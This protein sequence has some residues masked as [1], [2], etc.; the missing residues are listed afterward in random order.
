MIRTA[1][2]MDIQNGVS[3]IGEMPQR[4]P[5]HLLIS[6]SGDWEFLRRREDYRRDWAQHAQHLPKKNL[7]WNSELSSKLPPNR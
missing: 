5:N 4:T 2:P 6:I 1:M 7:A 3:Q